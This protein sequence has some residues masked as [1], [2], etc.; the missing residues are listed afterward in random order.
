MSDKKS[1]HVG[2]VWHKRK[3]KW[4]AY[5]GRAGKQKYLGVFDKVEDA[6]AAREKAE[7]EFPL[8]PRKSKKSKI[9]YDPQEKLHYANTDMSNLSEIQRVCLLDYINGIR[10]K[11]IAVKYK[12]SEA[13][14][15]VKIKEAK[16]IIDTGAAYSPEELKKRKEY[17][18]NYYSE[19]REEMKESSNRYAKDHTESMREYG[20]RYYEKNRD[21][22]INNM[23]I[24]NKEYYEKN[25][26]RLIA[27]ARAR[28]IPMIPTSE[29][30][31]EI[32]DEYRRLGNVNAVVAKTH[33]S[34]NRVVK[35][36]SNCGVVIN[37]TH[38]IILNLHKKGMSAREI[39]EKLGLNFK[40]VQSYLPRVRPVYG[41]NRSANAER[42]KEWR[43]RNQ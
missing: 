32:L 2:V 31:R 40:K 36:L 26:E 35:S 43:E 27:K 29:I 11:D 38:R 5:I 28:R 10:V 25:R 13:T 3:G 8:P 14:T 41:E 4:M 7:L 17:Y 6:I 12:I 18:K 23:K 42:I 24:Y 15:Y 21:R 33:H 22:L 19:H 30:E 37:D 39:A 9:E 20:K 1:G 16:R 34:W